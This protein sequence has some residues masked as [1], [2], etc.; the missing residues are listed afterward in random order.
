M[1]T[2]NMRGHLKVFERPAVMGILNVNDDSFHAA[3]RVPTV[4]DCVS[5][6]AIMAEEGAD[7]L[8]VGGQSTRPGSRRIDAGEEASRVLPVI[9][10]LAR[11]FPGLP[12]SVDTYHAEVAMSAVKAGATMVNDVSAGAMDPSMIAVVAGLG[13][14]FICMHMQGRPET[15][16][17]APLYSDVVAEVYDHLAA[18]L[19]VCRRAGIRDVLI[20]PGF[21]FGKTM[22]HNFSI[23]RNLAVFRSLGAPLMVGLS[24]KS[25]VWRSLGTGPDE[26]LNGTTVLHAFALSQGA[27]IL[28]VHDVREAVE[29]VR[30]HGLTYGDRSDFETV[31]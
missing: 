1:F 23:L 27:D 10:E 5:K 13:V 12:L 2:L 19:D 14:P 28:R 22:E 20:D 31:R 9:S 11:R 3:S 7:I 8:D 16:Q 18:R 17:D 15:M 4:E 30:L 26:A 24:R 25:M 6:A 21:G 29:A